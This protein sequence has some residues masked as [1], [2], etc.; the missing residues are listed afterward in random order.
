M[1]HVFNLAR[2]TLFMFVNPGFTLHK[3]LLRGYSRL[4]GYSILSMYDNLRPCIAS[5]S[6]SKWLSMEIMSGIL[7][8]GANIIL[9]TFRAHQLCTVW[10]QMLKQRLI[11]RKNTYFV[12]GRN[13]R[14]RFP[15]LGKAKIA[16][17]AIRPAFKPSISFF[18]D[19]S[20]HIAMANCATVLPI[21]QYST[22]VRAQWFAQQFLVGTVFT[23][24]DPDIK[25]YEQRPWM[26][27][28]RMSWWGR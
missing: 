25:L 15:F 13:W 19:K 24:P 12:V 11:T 1:I 28:S 9:V 3:Y 2:E 10:N 14:K 7:G 6:S 26:L 27:S 8:C 20:M 21:S 18:T 4:S 16:G 22:R 17:V 23:T 5:L